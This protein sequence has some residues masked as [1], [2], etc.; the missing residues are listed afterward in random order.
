MGGIM[1]DDRIRI[2]DRRLL[3]VKHCWA[4]QLLYKY[5]LLHNSDHVHPE[6]LCSIKRGTLQLCIG[7]GIAELQCLSIYMND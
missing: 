1:R 2:P 6:D 3:D 7:M 4:L 5:L